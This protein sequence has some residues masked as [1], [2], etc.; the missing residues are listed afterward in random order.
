M[1]HLW[2]NYGTIDGFD[3]TVN[4]LRMT[5]KWE[6]PTPIKAF[7]KQLKEGQEFASKGNKT[8][9][10]SQI[11]CWGY[12]SIQTTGL[13]ERDCKKWHNKAI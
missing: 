12:K 7:F 6:S 5:M 3:K 11:V 10:D 1:T 2:T 4:K 8:V 9:S 13:F